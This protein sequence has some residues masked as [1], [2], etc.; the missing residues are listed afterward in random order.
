MTYC[1][2]LSV[3]LVS[4]TK[5]DSTGTELPLNIYNWEDYIGS[6]TVDLFTEKTGIQVNMENYD[7]EEEMFAYIRSDLSAYDLVIASD[8][9][10]R[11][12]ITARILS[13]MDHSLLPNRSYIDENFTGLL[14]D[15]R[16]EYSIPYLWGTTGM[17]VNRKFIKPPFRSWNVLFQKDYS[18]K[19]AMLNNGYEVLSASLKILNESI[20][21]T[22][23]KILDK[24]GNKLY[25]QNPLVSGYFD[26]IT[27]M[28]KLIS[29]ELWAAQ[30]YSGEGLSACDRNDNLEYII[31]EEGAPIW[32]DNFVIPRDAPNVNAAHQFIDFILEPRI[33]GSIASE[34]WYA[35]SN[36]EALKFIDEEVL[37]SDSVFPDK[38]TLNRCEFYSDNGAAV[39]FITELWSALKKKK[40]GEV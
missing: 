25:E 32:L 31:P 33:N 35:T 15:P 40:D 1:L 3:S 12:M 22:D 26:A 16:N 28:N 19:V 2:I 34:L 8:D 11:E 37:N 30:I 39:G 27:I 21:T 20:N 36:K 9:L 13:P 17:V 6:E 24:A 7:D 4:C 38:E 14:F 23:L 29:E 5:S 10:V 18:R